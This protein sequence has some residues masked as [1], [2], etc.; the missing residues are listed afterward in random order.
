VVEEPK[1][2]IIEKL[3]SMTIEEASEK[4]LIFDKVTVN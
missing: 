3:K 4:D 2:E 1:E